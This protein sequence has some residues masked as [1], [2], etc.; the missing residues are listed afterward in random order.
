M[1]MIISKGKNKQAVNMIAIPLVPFHIHQKSL[2]TNAQSMMVAF[3]STRVRARVALGFVIEM[4]LKS[5]FWIASSAFNAFCDDLWK[6]ARFSLI[7]KLF[8]S[9]WDNQATVST[10]FGCWQFIDRT[11]NLCVSIYNINMRH[12]III[13]I[14]QLWNIIEEF[15]ITHNDKQIF[16]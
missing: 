5:F 14:L 16:I 6:R 12:L 9:L 15:Q 3:S 11:M 4:H 13:I 2:S 7:R 8:C 1:M 10:F